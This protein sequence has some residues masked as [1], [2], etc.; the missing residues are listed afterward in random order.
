MPPVRRLGLLLGLLALACSERTV[1]VGGPVL[2]MDA[3]DRVVEALG[4]EGGRIAAVG[5]R[6]ELETWAGGRARVVELD[7]HAAARSAVD[8]GMHFTIHCDSPVVPMEPLR[9]VWA[10]VNR[11]SASGAAIG[12]AQRISPMQALRAVTIDAAY[13]HFEEG[14]KGS[15]EPGKLAD[16]VILS[17]S[18]LEEPETI[19]EIRVL[20][21]IVGGETVWRAEGT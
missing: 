13:Q 8:R 1:Y 11:R 21:T 10:A 2:T 5:S 9:L 20:E 16:L 14:E 4:V 3:E 12:P 6:A 17:R 15:L 19:D 7:G 18:P